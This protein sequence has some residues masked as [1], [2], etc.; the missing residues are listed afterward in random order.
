MKKNDANVH[1]VINSDL[2][3]KLQEEAFEKGVPLSTYIRMII[4]ER[5]K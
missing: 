2:K 4:S 3:K 1:I 5:G